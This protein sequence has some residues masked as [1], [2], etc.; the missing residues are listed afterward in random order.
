MKIILILSLLSSQ[1]CTSLLRDVNELIGVQQDD[2]AMLAICA[3]VHSDNP[4][5]EID[6]SIRRLEFPKDMD[7]SKVTPEHIIQ[8]LNC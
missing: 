3:E 1:S 8:L 2:N 4:L 6:I 7:V 5:T